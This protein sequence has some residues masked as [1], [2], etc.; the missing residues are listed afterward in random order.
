MGGS[1]NRDALLNCKSTNYSGKWSAWTL[2]NADIY[3]P[4]IN[5]LE[6]SGFAPLPFY[7]D[8]RKNITDTAPILASFV[9]NNNAPGETLD[10][11]GHSLGGLGGRGYLEM[12]QTNSRLGKMLT[13]GSPHQGSVMAYPAWSGGVIWN[14]DIRFRL[15][16]TM[17]QI[18]CRLRYG[19]S[20]RETINTMFPSVQNTLPTFDYLK[21]R[22]TQAVKPVLSMN[23]QNNWLPTPFES[24]FF[25][26]TVGTLAGTGFDT[27]SMLEVM[28]PSRNDIRQGNWLDGKPAGRKKYADGDG[29]VLAQSSSLQDAENMTLPLDHAGLV[30]S[31]TGIDTILSFLSGAPTIQSF[32]TLNL[33]AQGRP[34]N[35]RDD[36]TALLIVV[37]GA[38]ATLTDKDGNQTKDSEGQI[39]IIDPH[40][41][42]YTLT[43]NPL[44][45]WWWRSKYK[46]I[47]VQ[48]FED[49]TSTWKEYSNS[50][51][52]PKRWKL[53][54]DHRNKHNDILRDR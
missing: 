51:L 16:A 20:P 25:G 41:E 50:G 3:Q 8:W 33:G 9:Q 48:L 7:Y 5:N 1:W 14:D 39:T 22:Q 30:S 46:V 13:V 47:V 17:L 35:P 36:A 6:N 52:F 32:S 4:L 12:T 21:D 23:A 11:V 43:I 28:P 31:Q 29:T 44:K 26:V 38:S 27:L 10:V 45:R 42:A 2:A 34:I 49:G 19:W 24:P 37:D 18:G 15:G 54:F 53:R 40:N